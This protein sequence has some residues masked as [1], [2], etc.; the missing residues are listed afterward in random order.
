MYV[1]QA[2]A[3]SGEMVRFGWLYP[4]EKSANLN[5]LIHNFLEKAKEIVVEIPSGE[6]MP[7]SSSL[8]MK[9]LL[10]FPA[11]DGMRGP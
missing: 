1:I 8:M 7:S 9:Y 2:I 5:D 6:S 10:K 4:D 11:F 3:P